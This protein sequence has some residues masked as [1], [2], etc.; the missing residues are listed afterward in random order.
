LVVSGQLLLPD[1]PGRVKIA[2]GT[3]VIRGE[4]IAGVTAGLH[5]SP[6]FGGPG[7][8]ITPGFVDTH[9]H[10]PQFDSI[11]VDGME[12]L[13][14]LDRVIFP[15][16]ARWAD[17]DYAGAMATRVAKELLSVGTT[18]VASYATVHHE[19][20]R[21]AME[22]LVAVG[23]GGYVGQVL[24]DRNAPTELLR[25]AREALANAAKLES[26]GRISP[27]VTPRFAL[28]CSDEMLRGAAALA[29]KTGW[30]VQT[31]LA[32][33]V[34][35]IEAVEGMY[36]G[37]SYV[38]VYGNRGLM[39][40]RTVLGHGVWLNDDDLERLRLTG[41]V[42][43][44]CPT[45]NRFLEAGEMSRGRALKAGVKVS[46]GSDVAGG[47]DRSMVRV[48][49]GMIETAKQ[50]K[51]GNGSGPPEGAA[52]EEVQRRGVPSAAEAWWQITAGN[53]DAIGLGQT[54]RLEVGAWADVVVVKPG[55]TWMGTM[56]PLSTVLWG[57]DDR[58]IEVTL[59]GGSLGYRKG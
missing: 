29:D 4:R 46:L 6:D 58:W 47:P 34:R 22:A 7:H 28:S 51:H 37:E 19:A 59:A 1:G 53:A 43:A 18:S 41:A 42:I 55:P 57:W 8:L 24:M 32:E 30:L 49:R 21:A 44:H 45:A 35:E 54:G 5:P 39:G 52:G 16:E 10:L 9:L 56:D 12:L 48:A 2:P 50:I 38:E 20:T 14:W 40:I 27:A 11:G 31:H 3:V 36:P 23:M 25:P 33:T 13:E 15:A 26:R 17:P